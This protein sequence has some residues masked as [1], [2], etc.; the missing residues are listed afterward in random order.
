MSDDRVYLAYILECI[1]NIEDMT[2]NGRTAF[3]SVKHHRAAALYYLQT[4]SETTQ[5]ISDS[6]KA[7][8]SDV[9]WVAIS[10]FRNRLVH[11]YLDVDMDVVWSVI[12]NYLP[13]LKQAIVT[14][15]EQLDEG[16]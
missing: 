12:K 14:M 9:D 15:F 13:G 11:G 7:S 3:E 1:T 2:R 16:E 5:R 8:H 4:M 6:L 10:G